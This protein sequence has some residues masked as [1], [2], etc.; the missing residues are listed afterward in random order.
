MR[1]KIE[2]IMIRPRVTR[3]GRGLGG[4][5]S[6]IFNYIKPK[7]FGLARSAVKSKPFKKIVNNAKNIALDTGSKVIDDIS[8]GQNVRDSIK[9]NLR[10]GAKTFAKKT[11]DTSIETLKNMINP[12]EKKPS[13]KPKKRPRKLKV[14][15]SKKR[16]PDIFD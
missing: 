16:K 8:K 10:D 5:L 14:I 9:S 1:S 4:V 12:R 6:K 15:S 2:A 13:S 11:A 7:I 3:Y